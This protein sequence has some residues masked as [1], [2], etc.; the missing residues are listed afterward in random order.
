MDGLLF[1]FEVTD[2]FR[3][4]G[5][6]FLIT[7][8]K[9]VKVFHIVH[10]SVNNVFDVLCKASNREIGAVNAMISVLFLPATSIMRS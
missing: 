10:C 4:L 3:V 5:L 6:Q 9:P 1:R 2:K 7:L 8:N